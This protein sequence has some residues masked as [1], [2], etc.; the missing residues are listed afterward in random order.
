[1]LAE[2]YPPQCGGVIVELA[3]LRPDSVVALQS[4]D[5]PAIAASS[6]TDYVAGVTGDEAD[7]VLTNVVLT[8]PI[9]RSESDGLVVRIADLGLTATEPF[10]LPIDARNITDDDTTLTFTSGQRVEFT[11]SDDSGE[12]Y[13]WSE[14]M[15]FTQ[16][17]ETAELPAGSVYGTT[18]TGE[19]I[20]VAPGTYLAKAWITAAEAANVVVE[21]ETTV[22]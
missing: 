20:G 16:A 4:P 13:R 17:I 11:L 3:D 2:S 8:D 14:G 7:G 12:V 1:A 6:W 22:E 19:P 9:A 10:T 21:W 15:M 18:L 5:D